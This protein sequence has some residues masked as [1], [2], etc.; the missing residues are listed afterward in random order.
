VRALVAAVA[1][2]GTLT[3]DRGAADRLRPE[4]RMAFRLLEAIDPA[5]GLLRGAGGLDRL[6]LI[7]ESVGEHEAAARASYFWNSKRLV[8]VGDEFT[9]G[10]RGV[11]VAGTGVPRLPELPSPLSCSM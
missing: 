8:Q 4:L 2:D 5:T 7:V 10:E 9:T 6:E 1:R 11:S 3:L